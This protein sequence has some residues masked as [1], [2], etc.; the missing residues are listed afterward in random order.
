MGKEAFKEAVG[1]FVESVD[2]IGPSQWED[3]ALGVWNV[4]ELVGHAS[5]S[6]TRAAEYAAQ[7]AERVDI[8]SAAVHYHVSL[9]REGTDDAIAESGRAAGGELGDDPATAI[10]RFADESLPVVDGV[11]ED[12]LISYPSGGIRFG[13]YLRT[14]VL[15]LTVHTLDLNA[16]TGVDIEPPREA[17]SVTLHLL[18]DL[19]VDSGHGGALALAAT[20][21]GLLPDRFSVLG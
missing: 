1:F 9:S 7:R 19:A 17:L 2:R 4:R 14:R 13:E 5:R 21:R 15:E 20:G 11:A 6:I 12:A 3:P 16:A 10:R 8:A 18:A